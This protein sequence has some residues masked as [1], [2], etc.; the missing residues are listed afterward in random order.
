V[1]RKEFDQQVKDEWQKHEIVNHAQQWNRKVEGLE[2][3]QRKNESRRPQ[4]YRPVRMPER[5][6][7]QP[8]ISRAQTPKSKQANHFEF[9]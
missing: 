8:Q 9:P 5:K 3:V 7:Q 2:C 1:Q 4:P 6:P